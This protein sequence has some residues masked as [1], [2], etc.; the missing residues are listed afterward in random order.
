M[1]LTRQEDARASET[2]DAEAEPSESGSIWRNLDFIKLWVGESISLIGTQITQFTLPLI[3]VLTLHASVFQVGLLNAARS[4]PIVVVALFA[5]VWVDR[6]RR[7]PILI[8]CALGCGVLIGLIPLASVLGVLSM[9]LMYA[10]CVLAGVLSVV[11]DVGVQSYVPSLVPRR[12]LA[13]TN[14]RLQTSLSLSMVAGP[15]LAG[16]LVGAIAA[17][18]TLTADAI[19]YFCCALGLIAIRRREAAPE[20]AA[21]RQSVRGSIAEGLRAVFGNRVLRA[22]LIQSGYFNLFQG[23]LITVLVVYA[24]KNL[25]LTPFQ[26]GVV[27]GA[28]AVGGLFGSM[29]ANKIRDA[30]D[31]GRRDHRRHPVPAAVADPAQFEP[32][33]DGDPG[34]RRVL[35]RVRRAD[36]QRQ[37]HHP[38][39]ERHAEPAARPDEL[40][41]P[42]G[43]ARHDPDRGHAVRRARP[44]R[45]AAL[46]HGDHHDPDRDPAAVGPVLAGLPAQDH[47]HLGNDWSGPR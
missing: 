44:G 22:L 35:L 47:A 38:A 8:G 12:H 36:V 46:G 33:I 16:I 6:Y 45:R 37:R 42:P 31:H 9:N 29:S 32:G 2:P 18:D 40:L 43:R 4:G 20:P 10:V 25:L 30:L 5:G 13:A 14:S 41:L 24:L 28:I 23:G 21:Q 19:S 34:R 26:L 17:P 3:A 1:A 7:R 39:P 11:F 15:G 27:L